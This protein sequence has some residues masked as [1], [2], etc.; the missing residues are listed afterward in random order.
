MRSHV[1]PAGTD[2]GYA[3][4][5]TWRAGD[6]GVGLE[7]EAHP[8]GTWTVPVPRLGLRM[9]L[10]TSF[11]RLTWFGLGPGE[12][13]S[14]TTTAQ[15]VGRFSLGV[16]ELQTPYVRPQENGNRRHV[17]WAE[18]GRAGGAPLRISGPDTVDVTLRPWTTEVLDAAAHRTDL[19]ADPDWHWLNLDVAQHGI[20]TGA[21]GPV[22]LP[23]YTLHAGPVRLVLDLLL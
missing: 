14:D 2:V 8:L 21:C 16:A 12:A 7:L 11:G 6:R 3:S 20:G 9:G 15:R 1:L 5:L 19:V 17:R 4:V 13:Y 23:S 10:P 22:E 18:V